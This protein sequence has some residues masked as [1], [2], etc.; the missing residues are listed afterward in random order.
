MGLTAKHFKTIFD[1]L[2]TK[3]IQHGNK[4]FLEN[5]GN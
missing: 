4:E 3:E 5:N 1:S 2:V